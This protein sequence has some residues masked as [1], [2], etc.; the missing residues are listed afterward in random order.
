[1]IGISFEHWQYT[2]TERMLIKYES[3]HYSR[4]EAASAYSRHICAHSTRLSTL[5]LEFAER[6]IRCGNEAFA[7]A[8]VADP[9]GDLEVWDEW[10]FGTRSFPYPGRYSR[11]D[12][13]R[14]EK[15]TSS[16]SSVGVI[17]EIMAGFFA[18]AGVS[19]WVLV[20]V[21]HRW[22]DFI[23][24]DREQT[25]SFV[26]SKAFTSEPQNG[27]GLSARVLPGLLAEGALQ[28]A[29]QLNSDPFGKVWSSFTRIVRVDPMQFEVTFLEFNVPDSRR[30]SQPLHAMP[31]A[32]ARGLA[33]RAVN[34]A[35]AQLGLSETDS[36]LT[37]PTVR[38]GSLVP[39]L[40]KRA[41]SEVVVLLSE[42]D[43]GSP[44]SVDRNPIDEAV[45]ALLDRIARRKWK[46]PKSESMGGR[47]FKDAKEEAVRNRLSRIR[48]FGEEW[49][50]LADLAKEDVDQVRR[51]WTPDWTRACSPWKTIDGVDLWRCG[52]AVIC[53]ADANMDGRAIGSDAGENGDDANLAP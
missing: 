37:D 3:P 29:Q 49:F 7:E 13:T 40:R 1:M 12:I 31:A 43:P 44:L 50:Y 36:R 47:R 5:E 41:E 20:R 25:Y 9:I 24:S 42:I 18:Q 48:R 17:G 34:Q 16:P 38:K 35:A 33:E 26:E 23:F 19:P 46:A 32:V 30:L 15:K 2:F 45:T 4:K 8:A 21:V 11:L 14:Q 28:A 6:Q 10:R 39:E 52:G 51:T 27:H 22:P 53:L